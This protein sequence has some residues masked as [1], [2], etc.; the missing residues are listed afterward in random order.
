MESWQCDAL[1][2]H[3]TMKS[4]ESPREEVPRAG[5]QGR[6]TLSRATA[7][8][9]GHGPGSATSVQSTSELEELLRSRLRLMAILPTIGISA[10][11]AVGL[12]V[13][14]RHLIDVPAELFTAPPFSS[15]CGRSP[16]SS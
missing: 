15:R 14:W 7:S 16:T 9:A 11:I 12:A 1:S 8:P 3:R 6:R 4:Q 5:G 13:S 10:L 2:D